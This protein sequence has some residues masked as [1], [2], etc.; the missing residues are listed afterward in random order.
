LNL[1]QPDR[2]ELRLRPDPNLRA[3]SA[4]ERERGQQNT[5]NPVELIANRSVRDDSTAEPS[6]QAEFTILQLAHG[7]AK[8]FDVPVIQRSFV[9]RSFFVSIWQPLAG[10]RDN[11]VGS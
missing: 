3:K 10:K 5:I 8:K 6:K 2:L 7:S 4:K 9:I 1:F 11:G